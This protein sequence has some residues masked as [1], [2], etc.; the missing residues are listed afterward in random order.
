MT[1]VPLRL[2]RGER[3]CKRAFDV[4]VALLTLA[5]TWWILLIAL[6]AATV[7][8]RKWG[9]FTQIRIGQHGKPFSILKIRTLR[10][11]RGPAVPAVT[12]SDPRVTRLGRFLRCTKL[13]ELPQLLN[14]L[15]GQMSI[16]GPRPDEPGL[17]DALEGPDR[18]ILTLKP[19]LTGPATL[20]FFHEADLLQQSA[21]PQRFCR[22]VLYPEKVRLNLDYLENY[23]LHLDCVIVVQ[24]LRVLARSALQTDALWEDYRQTA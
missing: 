19:G 15:A 12:A 8:C 3:R 14:V 17:A 20:R 2:T 5:L 7:S 21:D 23:S 9:L 4:V 24:T 16:V 11:D 1:D 22:E 18:L 6:A 13:D 10:D